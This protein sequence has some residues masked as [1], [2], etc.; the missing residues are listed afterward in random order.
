M[1]VFLQKVGTNLSS[2]KNFNKGYQQYVKLNRREDVINYRCL[3]SI[4]GLPTEILIRLQNGVN[5]F[6]FYL[7]SLFILFFRKRIQEPKKG[8]KKNQV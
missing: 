3:V 6:F 7:N 5:T 4:I 2:F 1:S 8:G